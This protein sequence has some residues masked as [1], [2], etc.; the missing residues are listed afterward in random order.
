MSPRYWFPT[1]SSC[2]QARRFPDTASGRTI[3]PPTPAASAACWQ[4]RLSDCDCPTAETRDTVITLA[5]SSACSCYCDTTPPLRTKEGGSSRINTSDAT[6]Q[7]RRVRTLVDR[8]RCPSGWRAFLGEN[9]ASPD[10]TRSTAARSAFIGTASAL[11][12]ARGICAAWRF[13]FGVRN[14]RLP[15]GSPQARPLPHSGRASF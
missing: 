12:S 8:T 7:R 15:G 9:R 11:R 5:G 14:R 1:S 13:A 6:L 2:E 4:A 3:G 10:A